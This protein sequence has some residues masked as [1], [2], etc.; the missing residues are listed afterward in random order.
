VDPEIA[1]K[2][3]VV[4]SGRLLCPAYATRRG[5]RLNYDS[6][7]PQRE[8]PPLQSRRRSVPWTTIIPVVLLG[9]IALVLLVLFLLRGE[10]GTASASPTP[11]ATPAPSTSPT[12]EPGTSAPAS[13]SAAPSASPGEIAIDSVVQTTA[14]ALAVRAEP[15]VGGERLGS[16]ALG[17]PGFVVDGPT[18]ADGFTWYLVSSLGLPPNSGCAAPLET[19]PFNCPSWFGW[20]AAAS[21]SGDPWLAPA[22]LDCPERPVTVEDLVIGRPKIER[23]ACM[24]SEPITFRAWWP[25]LPD[26]GLGG[27]CLA[28]HEPSG[29][30]LCQNINYNSVTVDENEGFGGLGMPISI[31]PASGVT[32]P[33]RQTW[34][35]LTAHFDDPAAQGCDEAAEVFPNPDREPQQFV[36][37]CRAELVVD[38]ATAV[39]GP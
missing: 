24:A 18:E 22:E 13:P 35:E 16:L 28:E 25:E 23:L 26:S 5:R 34:I 7:P 36:L 37:D 8:Q 11:T 27:A 4:P 21:E 33:E 39:D 38:S 29:W 10:E 14:G 30:L 20:V 12:V 6:Y 17:S 2:D 1:S 19:D 9:V 3:P 15:G 31:D 32:M